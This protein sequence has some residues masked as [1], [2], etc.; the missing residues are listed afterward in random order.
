MLDLVEKALRGTDQEEL[1]SLTLSPEEGEAWGL[2]RGIVINGTIKEDFGYP[3]IVNNYHTPEYERMY[4]RRKY[5]KRSHERIVF[6]SKDFLETEHCF[7]VSTLHLP[8]RM[9]FSW[10]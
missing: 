10:M 7:H 9:F 8:R 2:P 1:Q 5:L 3:S 4:A 6:L